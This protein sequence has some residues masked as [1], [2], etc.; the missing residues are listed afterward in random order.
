MCVSN[1]SNL[2]VLLVF[3]F[4]GR[5]IKITVTIFRLIAD[6]VSFNESVDFNE[7]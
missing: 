5:R 4:V 3:L 1:W 2:R 6:P 7:I